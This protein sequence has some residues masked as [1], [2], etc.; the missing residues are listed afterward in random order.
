MIDAPALSTLAQ[1]HRPRVDRIA[2]IRGRVSNPP[3]IC[4]TRPT[5]HQHGVDRK[6]GSRCPRCPTHFAGKRGGVRKIGP[7]HPQRARAWQKG[8]L[9]E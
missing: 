6:T 9:T 1:P 7:P 5:L 4:P 8:G 2:I 3:R